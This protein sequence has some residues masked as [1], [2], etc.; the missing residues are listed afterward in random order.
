[1]R[2]AELGGATAYVLGQQ[3]LAA[4]RRPEPLHRLEGALV[5]DGE[6]A[7]LLHVV[8]PEL[9]PQ[10]VLLG[11]R[12]D[13]DDAAADGEL[14][15][16]LDHVDPGVRRL[17]EAAHDVLQRRV[18]PGAS[19]TGSMSA[20][21][22]TCGW[23]RL[24]IGATTTLSGPLARVGAGVA[25]SAQ[26]R[27]AATDGVAAGAEP[28]VREGLPA[29]V[30]GHGV[31]I[32]EVGELL[33]QVLGLARRRGDR[34]DGAPARDQAVD[35]ERTDGPG[36]GQV[37]GGRTAASARAPAS[38]G[39]ATTRPATAR[40]GVDDTGVP[41]GGSEGSQ[42]A[43][44]KAPVREGGRRLEVYGAAGLPHASRGSTQIT[45]GFT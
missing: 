37:E 33:D 11:R 45:A 35:H 2:P 12:E 22:G 19:S 18:S 15:A 9:H 24:R 5:G 29:R 44:K 20:R 32:D 34:E 25:Q 17:G 7:D 40:S 10:R 41:S 14:A 3:Q 16:P 42:G 4:R 23:S 28:L 1:M 36:P 30:V 43:C 39:A 6:G 26:H 8:A 31:G 27:E 38:V 21:P 13:V